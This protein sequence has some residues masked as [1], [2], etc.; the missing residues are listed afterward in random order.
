MSRYTSEPAVK[1]NT[2]SI[3]PRKANASFTRI[4]MPG[5]ALLI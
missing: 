1:P 4:D 5:I 2:N 3:E